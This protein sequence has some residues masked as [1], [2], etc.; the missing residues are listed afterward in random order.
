MRGKSHRNLG[1]FLVWKYMPDISPRNRQAF[2]FGCIEP[3][4]NP[5]TYLKGSFRCQWLRGH[6]YR[7]ARRFMHLLSWRLEK[8]RK[9]TLLDY[10]ALGKL[11]HYIAD[12]FTYAHNDSFPKELEFHREYEA[13]LQEHFLSYLQADPQID[14]KT[15]RSVTEAISAYHREYRELSP[16]IQRDARYTLNACCCTLALLAAR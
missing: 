10:Y 9:W 15:A 8:K 2:L 12:A 4:R 14:L 5:F 7:N 3:D 6:N 16:D 13:Q 1:E 11:I